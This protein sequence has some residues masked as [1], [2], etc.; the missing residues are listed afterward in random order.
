MSKIFSLVIFLALVAAAALFGV[1]FQPGAWYE[2]LTKPEWTPPNWVFGP[3]W[4]VIY[5]M[6]AI[7]GW[8][9][10]SKQG[11]SVLLMIWL[12]SLAINAA[13]SWIMFGEHQIGWAL[14][15]IW[16][17]L[18]T[19]FAFILLAWPV[20]RTAALLFVPYAAWVSYASALNFAIWQLN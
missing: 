2:S 15:D 13:W 3:V 8:R 19:I 14:V 10:W 9:I 7:A 17:L 18:V 12:I 11:F 1:M 5:L 16:A 6:I 4:S 20:D